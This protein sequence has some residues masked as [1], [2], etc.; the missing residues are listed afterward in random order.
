MPG[1]FV[2]KKNSW[3]GLLVIYTLGGFI[4]TI[5]FGQLTAF[6]P[7]YLP[8]L[9]IAQADVAQWTGIV[10]A[11]TGL[12]GLP[13]LPF[14]G[15]LADRYSRKPIIIRSFAVEILAGIISL[16]A[17]NIWIF[18][19][20]R[21]LTC[22]A[23][24][25]SGLMMTTLSERVPS[26]RQGLAF[27]VMNSASPVGVFLGP[28]A[29]GPIVDHWGFPTL[30]AID[31]VLLT[32]V[33]LVMIF[34]Y[35]DSFQGNAD[36]PLLKMAGDSIRIVL[37]SSRLRI[38][39][40][41][42]FVLFAGWMLALTYAAL[43]IGQ[44][45]Q[46]SDQ[47]TIVGIILGAGGILAMILG[48]AIGALAD[49]YGYWKMLLVGSIISVLLWPIPALVK[50]IV[51][52]GVAWSLINGLTSGVF[53]LSFSVLSRSAPENIRGR[54][55]SFA[56]LPVNIGLFLGPAIGSIVTQR[57]VF[58][59]FP[60]AAVLTALGIILLVL[61]RNRTVSDVDGLRTM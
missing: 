49:R 44:L 1:L 40:V 39:F 4:E 13:F 20:G 21:T 11:V 42:L 3:I 19:V 29:G 57:S 7:L 6:T 56:Y 30:L 61:A 22:L 15:A 2:D 27:S 43:A 32:F 31:S 51:A 52:F 24:G 55:M 16:L 37:E 54:V 41:A 53:A 47:A 23:L 14:W 36:R 33:V 26:N 12:L 38:L 45:Y 8:K 17:G 5:F 46:G 28:L 25:N 50:T 59:I 18:M 48:P 35:R 60:A 34:G 9:G 58:A 10:A